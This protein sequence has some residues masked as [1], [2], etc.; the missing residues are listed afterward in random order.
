L[1]ETL[2]ERLQRRPQDRPREDK[3]S[4]CRAVI[5]RTGPGLYL[6]RTETRAG[7]SGHE[8]GRGSVWACRLRGKLRARLEREQDAVYIGEEVLVSH[9]VPRA[10]VVAGMNTSGTALIESLLPRRTTLFRLAPPPWP[11]TTLLK[12]T[13]AVNVDLVVAVVAAVAPPLK[14]GTIDRYLLLAA[15]AGIESA[16]CINKIDQVASDREHREKVQE[17]RSNLENR[18]VRV[19][20]TS[21]VTGEGIPGLHALISGKTSVFTGPSGVGKTSILKSMCPDLEAKTLTISES[22]NKGRHSTTYSS[23]ID[24]GGGYVADLPGLRAIGFWNLEDETVK[25]EFAD[26][27]EIARGCQFSDCS[28]RGEPGCAVRA[29]IEAGDLSGERF[30]AYVKVLRDAE[31][32]R[33][34]QDRS[35]RTG[36]KFR[37]TSRRVDRMKAIEESREEDERVLGHCPDASGS[38]RLKIRQVEHPQ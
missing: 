37:P 29:A 26:I 14:Q 31:K 22:T 6:A 17:I 27:E 30:A 13:L 4:L 15:Q 12:K 25:S 24:V 2:R 34:G 18:G 35:S 33:A 21:A 11:G 16:V 7:E 38:G 23:L 28:H 1:Q 10:G 36:R 20:L 3:N 8:V 9:L 32:S 5:V 19:V